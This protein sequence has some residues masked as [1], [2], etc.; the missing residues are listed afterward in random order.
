MRARAACGQGLCS[1]AVAA[2]SRLLSLTLGRRYILGRRSEGV[3]RQEIAKAL[4]LAETPANLIRLQ[5]LRRSGF[6]STAVYGMENFPAQMV[7]HPNGDA[8]VDTSRR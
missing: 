7:R 3:A 1:A 5:M 2:T 4:A 6:A 8:T